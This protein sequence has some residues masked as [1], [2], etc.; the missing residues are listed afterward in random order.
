MRRNTDRSV[1]KYV[2]RPHHGRCTPEAYVTEGLI[3]GIRGVS[4][5][6]DLYE[7]KIVFEGDG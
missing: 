3:T 6:S 2:R 5:R 1:W 4:R 7:W